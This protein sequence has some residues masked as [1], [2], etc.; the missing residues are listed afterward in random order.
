MSCFHL[1]TKFQYLLYLYCIFFFKFHSSNKYGQL[2][3]TIQRKEVCKI[4]KEK[5]KHAQSSI[6]VDSE[7]YQKRITDSTPNKPN[8]SV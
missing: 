5:K 6:Y 4:I 3:R 2:F 7:K 8:I 1:F